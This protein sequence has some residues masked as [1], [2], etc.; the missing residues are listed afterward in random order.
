MKETG[1][2]ELM[3]SQLVIRWGIEM[4]ENDG[5]S[6]QELFVLVFIGMVVLVALWRLTGC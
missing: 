2:L 6:C 3:G 1:W 5:S 4:V